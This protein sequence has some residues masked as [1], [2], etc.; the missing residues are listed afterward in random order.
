M[1]LNEWLLNRSNSYVYYKE[2]FE[3][4][5]IELNSKNN[6]IDNLKIDLINN[7][8]LINSLNQ[9]IK[10]YDQLVASFENKLTYDENF[11]KK[12]IKD[13]NIAYVLN[14]FPVHSE[15]FVVNE[16]KWLMEN[17]FNIFIFIYED[18]YKSVSIDFDIDINKF[19]NLIQLESLL[20]EYDIDLMHTHFVYPICTN[21]TYPISERLK[22]PFTVF[23]HAFDIFTEEFDE[24][25]KIEE[26]SNS[27][28][29]KAIFTL[30]DFHKNYLLER[31]VDEKK[32]IITKQATSYELLHIEQKNNSIKNI[33]SVS[34]FVE[35]KGLDVLIDAA[36]LLEDKGYEF[37][38]YGFGIL[39]QNLQKK[40]DD[41][42]C[43]NISIKGELHPN[44]V[45]SILTESDL[46]VSPCKVAK[47][48]DMDGFPTII[49][50]SMAVGLPVLTTDVSA[51]PEIIED[52]V[53]G[54]ITESNNPEKLAEKILEISKV[55]SDDLYN[56]RKQAQNDVKNISSVEK[57]MKK[58]IE[59]IKLG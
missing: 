8:N 26:I 42:N 44:E 11:S 1:R 7:K 55:T 13:L 48:G 14:S 6:Q 58:Y 21:F 19:D 24:C 37:S 40:I 45:M 38:I 36:K 29:C 27:K 35:K 9:K 22:I 34:R 5:Q 50:E 47:N 12:P 41:L 57:T 20:I 52:G 16:V 2:G 18:P 51:I 33:I 43:G 49:F 59:T 30:S 25:N 32:I 54:F 56:I 17:N 46:L 31:G 3:T 39:Q 10:D 28:Y 4:T 15:T 53:N 23:A